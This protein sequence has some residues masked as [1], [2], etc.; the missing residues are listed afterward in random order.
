MAKEQKVK[1]KERKEKWPEVAGGENRAMR[2][3]PTYESTLKLSLL[4]YRPSPGTAFTTKH[5]ARRRFAIPFWCL[6]S[7]SPLARQ[8]SEVIQLRVGKATCRV[9]N[10]PKSQTLTRRQRLVAIHTVVKLLHI[11]AAYLNA[12]R[13]MLAWRPY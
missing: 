4:A 10:L 1:A 8:G 6:I 5:G 3:R 9:V 12:G 7:S 2:L 13:C 11:C